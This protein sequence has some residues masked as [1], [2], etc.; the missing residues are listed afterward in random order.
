ML[1]KGRGVVEF[2]VLGGSGKDCL[3]VDG[4]V[5]YWWFDELLV[6]VG[7][8][9]LKMCKGLIVGLLFF[10]LVVGVGLLR[11]IFWLGIL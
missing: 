7:F 4:G 10:F 8:W 6:L 5:G 3:K 11:N 2:E 1:G 9:G